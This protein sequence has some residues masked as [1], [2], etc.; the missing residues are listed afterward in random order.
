MIS[1]RI[2]SLS[3]GKEDYDLAIPVYREALRTAGFDTEEVS[4]GK[5]ADR[6]RSGRNRGRK[7][8]WY[9]PPFNLAVRTN[10]SRLFES[11][12]EKAFPK[13]H[14]YLSKLFNK[15]NMRLSYSTTANLNSVIASH[16]RKL[17]ALDR[18]KTTVAPMP[19]GRGTQN[20]P[21]H[22]HQAAPIPAKTCNCRGGVQSCPLR[23]YCLTQ[24]VV[25]RAEINTNVAGDKRIYFGSTG[26]TFKERFNGHSSSLSN[27]KHQ[28][29]TTLSTYAWQLKR[30]GKPFSI[31]WS[32]V[33]KARPYTAGSQRCNL[34]T[35][36]K[37]T[38]ALNIQDPIVLN[39]RSELQAKCRHRRKWLLSSV[40]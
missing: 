34:C 22:L 21:T 35:A 23:G 13:N 16:N 5:K 36:E 18:A 2:S 30:Q 26:A 15:R 8:M 4:F 19:K 38:I 10:L 17:L 12:I 1:D 9:T 7:I 24:G 20:N 3:S 27:E 40:R 37:A 14:P 31:S 6:P 29:D 11:I 25:Y 28:H 39:R 33:T 32:V